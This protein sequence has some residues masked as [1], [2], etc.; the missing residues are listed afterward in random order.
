[1]RATQRFALVALGCA[2][3]A[4][5][6]DTDTAAPEAPSAVASALP[7]PSPDAATPT[8]TPAPTDA[9]TPATS[10]TPTA[11]PS[12]SP[13]PTPSAS[14]TPAAAGFTEEAALAAARARRAERADC[15]PG[16]ADD[17]HE[18][19]TAVDDRML[20]RVACFV[21]AYQVSGE[22]RTWDGVTLAPLP[23]EQWQAGGV[24]DSAEVVGLVDVLGDGVTVANSVLYRGLG[25]CGLQQRWT[26]DGAALRLE[27][28]REQ[29]CDDGTFV[30]P[31]EWPVV[32]ERG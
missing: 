24:V 1:M 4:G 17:A 14:P 32:F 27:L 20:V 2:V 6:S 8:T 30:A 10:P 21:G 19:V 5:C 12:P 16:M 23:V 26:F 9:P 13:S 25:D 29:Q 22:L 28:A 18:V 7:S 15:E 11:S 31:S 3:L